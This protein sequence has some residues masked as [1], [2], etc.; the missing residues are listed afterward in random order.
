LLIVL[1][2]TIYFDIY[3]T[4]NKLK[5]EKKKVVIKIF[6][7]KVA[8]YILTKKIKKEKVKNNKVSKYLEQFYCISRTLICIAT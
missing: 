1:A 2:T 5:I 4:I 6:Y 8:R 7:Y 3:N